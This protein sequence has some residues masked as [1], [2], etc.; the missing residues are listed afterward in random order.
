MKSDTEII[1]SAF[2][3]VLSILQL[4]QNGYYTNKLLVI[5]LYAELNSKFGGCKEN[6]RHWLNTYN[7]HLGF[8]PSTKLSDELY[9]NA[10]VKYLEEFDR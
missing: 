9:L 2:E 5:R 6:M 3:K 8:S 7:N 1:N 4:P 10:M